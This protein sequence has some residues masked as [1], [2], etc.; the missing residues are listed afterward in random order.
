MIRKK[1][2]TIPKFTELFD[3]NEIQTI[4]NSFAMATGVASIITDPKGVPIT[5]PS[6]FCRLCKDIIRDTEKGLSNCIHSDAAIGRY[7]PDG[8]VIQCCLSGGLW[9]AGA[10][11]SVAGNH[12]ANWLVGQVR[13][14]ETD[15]N[16]VMAYAGVIGANQKEFN[17][18]LKEVTVMSQDQFKHISESVFLM[19]NQLSKQA[20]QKY[21]Q[22]LIIL[23]KKET[24]EKLNKKT[25][26]L[27]TAIDQLLEEIE[28]KHEIE[29]DLKKKN[30]YMAA[31]HETSLGMFSRLDLSRVLESIISRASKLTKTPNG[32]I[33]LYDPQKKVLE[34][35]SAVGEY[36]GLEGT[37]L[38]TGEG[39]AGKVWEIGDVLLIDDYQSWEGRSKGSK[40]DFVTSTIGV[41]LTS[42]SKIEGAIGLSHH[43]R[44]AIISQDIPQI[45][46]QF[47]KLATIAI[48]NSKLFEGLNF[49]LGK[50]TLLENERKDM[51]E[52]L[53]QSQKMEAVGTLA[54]GIAH[55]FNNI[56]FP[57]IGFS[58][59]IM[60][61]LP[62]D[63]PIR[64]QLQP[65]LDGAE[66]AK[67]LV[68]QILSFS[69]E[70]K[71]TFKPLK[72]QLILKEV[73]KLSRASLPATIKIVKDIPRDIGMVMADPIQIHQIVMNLITNALH[74]MEESGGELS[75]VL[76]ELTLTNDDLSV[77][78]I[79]P[80]DY[81]SIVIKD[82]GTGMDQETLKRIFEP[83]FTTK[84]VGKGTGLGLAVVHGIV[85]NLN[86]EIVVHSLKG[87]GSSFTLFLPKIIESDKDKDMELKSTQQLN[88]DETIL[89]I[90]D[91]KPI[92]N[93]VEQILI[94]FGYKVISYEKST[95][96]MSNFEDSPYNFDLVI[97][98]MTMPDLTGDKLIVE[99]KKIRPDIPVILCTGF[100]EKI[101]D[102]RVN[103]IKPDKILMKPSSKDELLKTIRLLLDSKKNLEYERKCN[104]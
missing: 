101:A 88:G 55:D 72:I 7:H 99:I 53:Q 39:I 104:E 98:D 67:E 6:N 74:S 32:F 70:T 31:L 43:E 17:L 91:E 49:E 10:S 22:D 73:L 15:I 60:H 9:D 38:K 94:R 13:N 29:K 33:Y 89:L 95:K 41:P 2:K 8:P 78:D 56:L 103:G 45:L 42:G 64:N 81:I 79:I 51:E 21:K 44:G 92:L 85:K 3:Q 90:D 50:R 40:F 18:A 65:V 19:A 20:Y 12:I 25:I 96:A 52:R 69:R 59:M 14:Q 100:S 66:R 68:Q 54:G 27:Q 97:T 61:D 28:S 16:K 48:D 71:Q 34:L 58:Q 62:K 46:E 5:E 80:G 23:E 35:K 63:S 11:I 77:P 37:K 57:I 4:Q 47:A 84:S 86:G 1:Q 30:E 75:V 36:A 102:K 24:Q 87:K 93:M 83:Y 26:Q 82:T 76:K